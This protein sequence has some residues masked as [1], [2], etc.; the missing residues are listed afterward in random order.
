MSMGAFV[1]YSDSVL[2]NTVN[3]YLI[4]LMLIVIGAD[5]FLRVSD[6]RSVIQIKILIGLIAAF[7]I[8]VFVFTT[9]KDLVTLELD[10]PTPYIYMALVFLFGLMALK[11]INRIGRYVSL[12]TAFARFLSAAIVLIILSTIPYIFYDLLEAKLNFPLYQITYLSHFLFYAATSLFFLAF[13]RVKIVGGVYEEL[14]KATI[15]DPT[16][17]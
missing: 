13:G 15:K 6:R 1:Y 12:S 2:I 7:I 8:L 3:F 9:K 10:Q 4:G 11:K 16:I 14:K 5:S 17:Q